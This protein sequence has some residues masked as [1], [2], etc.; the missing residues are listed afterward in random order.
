VAVAL[1]DALA[2]LR[3]LLLDP[4]RLV[5][6]VA[7]GRRHGLP[8]PAL[9]R[10]ELRPVDLKAGRRLLVAEWDGTQTTTSHVEP[11]AE[12]EARVDALLA[13]PYG[14]WH[15]ETVDETV[16]LRVTKKGAA[17]VHR[18]AAQ[19]AQRTGHD[20]VRTRVLA[21]EDPLFA[22]LDADADK[23][24]Q[25]EAFLRLLDPV[26]PASGERPTGIVDLG[27]GNAALTFAAY[28]HLTDG[29]GREARVVGVD[30]KA[31]ARE[32][33]EAT[34]AQLGWSGTVTF[35]EAG[36]VDA[37][38]ELAPAALDVVLALHAC[39]TATDD[40]L[41]RAVRWGAPVVLAA[42]CCHHDIQRQLTAAKP[43]EPYAAL[44]RH[45]ILRERFA[46]VLT[47]TVRAE[48]LRLLGY[49]VEVLE[50]IGS[51]HTPRNT[52]IRAVRTG[53]A[54]DAS[55]ARDYVELTA[56]WQVQPR[57]AVLLADELQP[58]LVGA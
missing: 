51:Q 25:V 31:Q 14:N 7:A 29:L 27:C 46:D 50:F 8:P 6:A 24:R 35:V 28:R 40:A 54:P 42:P 37:E 33:N 1:A 12:A 18:A 5:R 16:Q 9:P 26:L 44:V 3:T 4:T 15:V 19:R 32:H 13:E 49:R 48:L 20:R 17:Q 38:V 30:V 58:V 36:I 47:D 34:A 2:D 53:A 57:L 45:G 10:V 21:D 22:A 55:R 11:G 52:L 56:Q 43:P 23:R 41:A 39:D